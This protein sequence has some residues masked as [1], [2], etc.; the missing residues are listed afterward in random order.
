VPKITKQQTDPKIKYEAD[1]S[2]EES[3]FVNFPKEKESK[4]SLRDK[5]IAVS[6]NRRS[7]SHRGIGSKTRTDPVEQSEEER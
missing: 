5:K 6:N 4:N 1:G 2:K 3:D 7:L